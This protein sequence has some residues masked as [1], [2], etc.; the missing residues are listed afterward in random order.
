[1]KIDISLKKKK[2]QDT[3]ETLEKDEILDEV[4]NQEPEEEIKL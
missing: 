2:G 1:M 3:E 4:E